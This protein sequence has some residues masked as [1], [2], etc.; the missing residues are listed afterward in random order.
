MTVATLD[1]GG[2]APERTF[3]LSRGTLWYSTLQTAS[4]VMTSLAVAS[5]YPFSCAGRQATWTV[6]VTTAGTRVR[7]YGPCFLYVQERAAFDQATLDQQVR[8][9]KGKETVIRLGQRPTAPAKFTTPAVQF[10]MK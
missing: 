5:V 8:L 1:N 10:W 9:P 6:E 4:Y 7:N 2:K 3:E